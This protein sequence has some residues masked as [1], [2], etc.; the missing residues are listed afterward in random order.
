[1]HQ[2]GLD[3]A[4]LAVG[5]DAGNEIE[6]E[7]PLRAL[8]VIVDRECDSAPEEREIDRLAALRELL[9]RHAGEQFLESAVV[10][11]HFSRARHHLVEEFVRHISIQQVVRLVCLLGGHFGTDGPFLTACYRI[12]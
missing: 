1:M 11:A 2:A 9:E 6:G 10:R 3:P 12:A 4:P 7:D 5:D 8:R